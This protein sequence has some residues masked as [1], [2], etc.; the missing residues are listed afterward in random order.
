MA[1]SLWTP[2]GEVPTRE[3]GIEPLTRDEIVTLSKMHEV[4]FNHDLVIFCKR[5]EHALSGQN[6]GSSKVLEVSCQCRSLR[7]DGR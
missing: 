7:Y 5:C 4:A 3:R 2:Q 1:G 6:N